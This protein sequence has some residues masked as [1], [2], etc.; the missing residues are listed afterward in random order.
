[1]PDGRDR[2]LRS[3][4]AKHNAPKAR[5]HPATDRGRRVLVPGRRSR[6]NGLAVGA[7]AAAGTGHSPLTAGQLAL[8][9]P[10]DPRDPS[11]QTGET[12]H[13]RKG[14]DTV[15]LERAR[16]DSR[17]PTAGECPGGTSGFS[18]S[19]TLVGSTVVSTTASSSAVGVQVEV[20]AQALGVCLHGLDRVVSPPI[21][22]PVHPLLDAAADRP[23]Q[24]CHSQG[25]AMAQLGGSALIPPNSCPRI[26]TT[27]T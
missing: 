26:S 13:G 17:R 11:G 27:P 24:G 9:A 23:E 21:E 3:L 15:R 8:S 1:M 6:A 12:S 16:P 18:Q 4:P 14:Q 25:A 10:T 2:Q 19:E 5:P 20:V 22:T 7:C